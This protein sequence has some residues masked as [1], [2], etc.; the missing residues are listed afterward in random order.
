MSSENQS[1]SIVFN[2]EMDR[3]LKAAA[4]LGSVNAGKF[5]LNTIARE[6]KTEETVLRR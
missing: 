2:A 6:E 5:C 3:S 1:I 4:A